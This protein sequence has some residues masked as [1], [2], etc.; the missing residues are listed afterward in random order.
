MVTSASTLWHRE[1]STL[2]LLDLAHLLRV[3]V[4]TFFELLC[5]PTA[6]KGASADLSLVR[7]GSKQDSGLSTPGCNSREIIGAARFGMGTEFCP[8]PY[9]RRWPGLQE[10][11]ESGKKD[12]S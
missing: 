9:Q 11:R 10:E 1:S 2:I 4:D 7:S 5:I 3:L 6:T 8:G 12:F